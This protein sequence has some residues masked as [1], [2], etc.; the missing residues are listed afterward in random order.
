MK[1][2]IV[3]R[4]SSRKLV[5]IWDCPILYSVFFLLLPYMM[6]YQFGKECVW[7]FCPTCGCHCLAVEPDAKGELAWSAASGI[8]QNLDLTGLMRRR[9]EFLGSTGDGGIGAWVSGV[10]VIGGVEAKKWVNGENEDPGLISTSF[11]CPLSNVR[12][13]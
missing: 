13:R 9:I 12:H 5:C 2:E 8:V 4:A 6:P 3:S 1:R 10:K 7:H 11:L